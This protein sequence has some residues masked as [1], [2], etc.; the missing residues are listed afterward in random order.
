[1]SL[2]TA[3][4]EHQRQTIDMPSE[5]LESLEFALAQ[6]QT[7]RS[8]LASAI[9]VADE[10]TFASI[11][12]ELSNIPCVQSTPTA[13][14]SSAT[15][16]FHKTSLASSLY[17]TRTPRDEQGYRSLSASELADALTMQD[18]LST[19]EARTAESAIT[20]SYDKAAATY[21]WQSGN[22]NTAEHQRK[23]RTLQSFEKTEAVILRHHLP[24]NDAIQEWIGITLIAALTKVLGRD[25][26][27]LVPH[28]DKLANLYHSRRLFAQAE[29]CHRRALRLRKYHYSDIHE[30]CAVNLEGIARIRRST[31]RHAEAAQLF[32]DAID[33]RTKQVRKLVFFNN[34]GLCEKKQHAA[35]ILQLLRTINELAQMYC[36]QGRFDDSA[37]QFRRALEL[38]NRLPVVCS[39]ALL[40]AIRSILLNY[41]YLMLRM[42]NYAEAEAIAA[43]RRFL[44]GATHHDRCVWHACAT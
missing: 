38:W 21:L 32:K 36:E 7:G 42:D 33:L 3:I 31:G 15:G 12:Q 5:M 4:P 2:S 11:A 1:M 40:M 20:G 26:S 13:A 44:Y 25:N 39:D 9:T 30:S 8:A 29:L 18:G 24:L 41:Q 16:A 43:R 34:N 37:R 28:L 14:V 6:S 35:A 19:P 27:H 23:L 10:A 22:V 17:H